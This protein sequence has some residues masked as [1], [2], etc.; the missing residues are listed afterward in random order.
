MC[1]APTGRIGRFGAVAATAVAAVVVLVPAVVEA[2]E[3]NDRVLPIERRT[4]AIERR[5][6]AFDGQ[7]VERQGEVVTVLLDADVLFEFDQDTLTP[8]AQE[9]LDELAEYFDDNLAGDVI[10]IV[11]H[12]DAR[13]DEAYNLDLSQQR[14]EAVRDHLGPMLETP[15]SFEVTGRGEAE[16]V[17]P[18]ETPDGADDPEGRRRNRRVEITFTATPEEPP[19]S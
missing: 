10:G 19:S 3:G 11:G 17:A 6:E 7:F 9:T 16:P 2:Q 4:V 18:N 12:T 13:G 5:V 8:Q 14:A 15:V 1:W